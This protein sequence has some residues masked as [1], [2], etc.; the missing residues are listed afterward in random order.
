MSAR[1]TDLDLL[2]YRLN[3]EGE[4]RTG[5]RVKYDLSEVVAHVESESPCILDGK[6]DLLN[7]T[8]RR[9]GGLYTRLVTTTD[10]FVAVSGC[11]HP[12][13]L[14]RWPREQQP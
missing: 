13:D 9:C 8:P 12:T 14:T 2:G 4:E 11:S 3:P 10:G 6:P 7:G 5:W 1:L